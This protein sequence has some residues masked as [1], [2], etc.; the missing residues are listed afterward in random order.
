MARAEAEIERLIREE[1]PIVFGDA[2]AIDKE[3]YRSKRNAL[4]D[5]GLAITGPYLSPETVRY[6]SILLYMSLIFVAL[7]L[8]KVV[9]F[10]LGEV[11]T[12]VDGRLLLMYALL[13]AVVAAT[14]VLKAHVDARRTFFMRV[15][16]SE[17]LKDIVTV[18]DEAQ[19]KLNIE[20]YYFRQAFDD[21]IATGDTYRKA[22]ASLSEASPLSA[23]A[24][25]NVTRLNVE[26]VRINMEQVRKSPEL[27]LKVEMHE[28]FLSLLRQQLRADVSRFSDRAVA[29]RS[30][31]RGLTRVLNLK[32]IYSDQLEPWI[33]ACDQLSKARL[34]Q[35]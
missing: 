33:K 2:S 30:H 13:I 23:S 14:F 35:H 16:N 6:Q 1:F 32:E 4:A 5:L 26:Q 20:H 17:A 3:E 22:L 18:L 25:P 19:E 24:N 34:V 7:H 29:L 10:K 8:F 27:T 21:M 9:S 11:A 15:K 31:E 28:A 12:V